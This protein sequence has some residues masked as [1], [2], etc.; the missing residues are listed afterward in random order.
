ML[1]KQIASDSG[2]MSFGRKNSVKNLIPDFLKDYLDAEE[3]LEPSFPR[4]FGPLIDSTFFVDFDH[5]HD[6]VTRRSF[7]GCIVYIRSTSV[8]WDSKRQGFIVSSIH[9]AEFSAL[10]TAIEE[11]HNL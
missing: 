2:T 3:E 7:I 4:S 9:V 5:A 8:C 6:L 11:S 10:C 1:N